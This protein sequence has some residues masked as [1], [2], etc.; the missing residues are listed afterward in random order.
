VNF[1]SNYG[2]KLVYCEDLS[3]SQQVTL[4][5]GASLIVSSHGSALVNL[6]FCNPNTTVIDI[7]NEKHINPCFWFISKINSLNY[8]YF[9]GK[10]FPI[11]NNSKNDNTWIDIAD[12]QE[13]FHTLGIVD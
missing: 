7:F 3:V 4:F 2:F 11:D 6:A 1:L 13:Y 5:S 12:F 10:A 9:P 8:H